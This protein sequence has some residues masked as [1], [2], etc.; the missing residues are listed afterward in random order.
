MPP[1]RRVFRWILILV[2]AVVLS[3]PIV[4]RTKQHNICVGRATLSITRTGCLAVWWPVAPDEWDLVV[5]E[6]LGGRPY[7]KWP[8]AVALWSL[9][10]VEVPHWL[11]LAAWLAA[12]VPLW[13]WAGRRRRTDAA[14]P[15]TAD[16]TPPTS[17]GAP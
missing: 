10:F 13:W 15:V 5:L 2:T 7:G 6:E 12:A 14:F 17:A 11:T 1:M 4:G 3:L 9:G 8:R 16:P